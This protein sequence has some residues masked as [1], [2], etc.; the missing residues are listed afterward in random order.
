MNSKQQKT[1]FDK[2]L[3][4]LYNSAQV[5]TVKPVASLFTKVELEF[6]LNPNNRCF[7][8]IQVFCQWLR[9]LGRPCFQNC[10][11]RL[12]VHISSV[13]GAAPPPLLAAIPA[14]ESA[15]VSASSASESQQLPEPSNVTSAAGAAS[16]VAAVSASGS[17]GQC[18]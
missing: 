7:A 14:A 4:A 8:S 16:D 17:L 10:I 6:A 11:G 5:R 2:Q 15:A 13:A 1:D 9:S 3:A 18:I 12:E